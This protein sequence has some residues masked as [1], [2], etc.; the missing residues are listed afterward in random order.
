M[1]FIQLPGIRNR[2]PLEIHFLQNNPQGL[3]GAAQHRSICHVENIATFFKKSACLERFCPSKLGE[4]NIRPARETVLKVPGALSMA[5]QYQ[6]VHRRYSSL[7]YGCV[8]FWRSPSNIQLPVAR[9]LYN[10]VLGMVNIRSRSRG[11]GTNSIT[12]RQNGSG[13][14]ISAL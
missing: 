4:T 2:Y 13:F 10:S 6:F 5:Y 14:A 12:R 1:T 11:R 7:F 9:F 8:K 3:N